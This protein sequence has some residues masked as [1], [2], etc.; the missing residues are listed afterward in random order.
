MKR[1]PFQGFT[2]P[3]V[4]S[5][6]KTKCHKGSKFSVNFFSSVLGY[7]PSGP[8]IRR[9]PSGGRGSGFLP[10]QGE[11]IPTG[12]KIVVCQGTSF[13]PATNPSGLI[14]CSLRQ[15]P[16]TTGRTSHFWR[17]A[18]PRGFHA[19]NLGAA[20]GRHPGTL[21][22]IVFTPAGRCRHITL[23]GCRIVCG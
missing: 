10:R 21:S 2:P 13:L 11:T 4:S 8:T 17:V 3:M 22:G 7:G 20:F 23:R 12:Q 14:D 1:Y 5:H 9:R 15:A 18:I 16:Q 19:Y 6:H